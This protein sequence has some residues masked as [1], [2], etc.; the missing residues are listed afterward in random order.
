MLYKVKDLNGYKLGA[1]NGEIGR[2]KDF[3][4][5]DKF[6]TVR[7]MVADTGNWLPGRKVLIS[8]HAV[9]SVDQE[10]KIIHTRLTKKQIEDSPSWDEDKPVSRQYEVDY[11]RHYGWAGYWYGPYAWGP[12]FYPPREPQ[13]RS[14]VRSEESQGDPNLRSS[15]EVSGYV[16]QAENGEIGHVDDFIIDD[17]TWRIR[18]MVVDTQNWWPGKE[19]LVSPQWISRVSWNEHSVFVN[20]KREAIKQAPEYD[21]KA[22]ITRDYEDR[23]HRHYNR[24]GYW[25]SEPL[26]EKTR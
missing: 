18:Y 2:I 3:Y 9:I 21:K 20:L 12:Y 7:Y 19:V 22:P 13:E 23:L 11:Y 1:S 5:D 10:E 16:I 6:W 25:T 15:N 14:E 24:E 26:F 4:F 8:P 17:E